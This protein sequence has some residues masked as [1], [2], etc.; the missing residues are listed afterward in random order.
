MKFLY[1]SRKESHSIEYSGILIT[2]LVILPF[3]WSLRH[4]SPSSARSAPPAP[5]SAGTVT[6]KS[7]R[8]R[9]HIPPGF[10]SGLEKQKKGEEEMNLEVALHEVPL[11]AS[12]AGVRPHLLRDE[13]REPGQHLLVLL[14]RGHHSTSCSI[15]TPAQQ[16]SISTDASHPASIHH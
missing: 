11:V 13:R 10:R 2:W 4:G 14:R 3:L 9:R 5:E 6:T 1:H 15:P 12:V 16:P 8:I 7:T